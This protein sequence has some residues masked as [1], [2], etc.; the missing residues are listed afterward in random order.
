M[1]ITLLGTGV[2]IPQNER[3]QSGLIVNSANGPVLFDC[4]S[5]VLQ[6]IYQSPYKHTSIEN[7]FLSHLHLDHCADFLSL[8]KANWLCDVTRINLWGPVGTL[9]WWN[10]LLCAYSYMQNKIDIHINEL[11]SGQTVKLDGLEIVCIT[12]VHALPSLGFLISLSGRTMLYTGDTEPVEDIARASDGIDLLIHECSFPDTFEVDNHTTPKRLAEM[13][14]GITIG[15]VILTHLYPQTQ[16]FEAEMVSV[17]ANACQCQVEIGHD[18][19][20]IE[21]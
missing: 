6:R 1:N 21:V 5:G 15:K 18:L 7:V 13:L 16:G 19:Q 9:K 12:T 10:D 11:S 2:G 17:I 8:V 14:R 3:V 4:G 20:E